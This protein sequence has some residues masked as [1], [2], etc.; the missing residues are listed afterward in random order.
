MKILIVLNKKEVAK[1]ASEIIVNQIKKKP[2]SVLGLATGRTMIPLYKEL[3]K[4]G[5]DFSRIKTFNLDEYV[6]GSY[7][8]YMNK[9]LFR[10]V[11]VDKKNTFFPSSSGSKY[12]EKIKKDGGIDL[13]ILGIGKNAHI[14][15]NEPG[16]SFKSKTRKVK[17]KGKYAY[18]V[19][20]ATIMKSR[21]ILLLAFGKEKS[22]AIKKTLKG[23]ISEE[24]PA[25]V[26]RK[27]KDVV[28]VVDGKAG[29]KLKS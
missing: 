26:L 2:N 16:S 5:V 24:V 13:Q 3:A 25:S 10:K 20:I 14:A 6:D 22:D 29:K 27:H 15:F 23:K 19:G 12:D 11:N 4:S 28:I 18:S 8:K 9:H 21:K 7:R 17:I 1:K